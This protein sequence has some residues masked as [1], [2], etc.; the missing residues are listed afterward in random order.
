MQDSSQLLGDKVC[1]ANRPDGDYG[2]SAVGKVCNSEIANT[3]RDRATLRGNP[4]V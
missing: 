1:V 2:R 4:V 3:L